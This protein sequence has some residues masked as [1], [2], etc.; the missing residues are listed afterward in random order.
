MPLTLFSN[1]ANEISQ[2]KLAN[3]KFI[4]LFDKKWLDCK[5]DVYNNC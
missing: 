3:Y 2:V 5:K 4:I 1:N